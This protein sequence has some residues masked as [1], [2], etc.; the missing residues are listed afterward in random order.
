MVTIRCRTDG[1]CTSR[2]LAA[3]DMSVHGIL[4]FVAGRSNLVTAVIRVTEVP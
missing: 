1:T 2:T 4:E 3:S